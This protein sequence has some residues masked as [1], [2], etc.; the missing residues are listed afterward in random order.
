[1]ERTR[2]ADESA[3][4]HT[5]AP[6]FRYTGNKCQ[7]LAN[8][9]RMWSTVEGGDV[10]EVSYFMGQTN[11]YLVYASST[12]G[13]ANDG[14]G[15]SDSCSQTHEDS[16]VLITD[17]TQFRRVDSGSLSTNG[18]LNTIRHLFSYSHFASDKSASRCMYACWGTP[19][20]AWRYVVVKCHATQ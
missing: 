18:V 14:H 10:N 9:V 17:A 8:K 1:M 3:H 4:S 6:L 2:R 20:T 13:F 7:G 12:Y 11:Q 19:N 16:R 5:H 15:T